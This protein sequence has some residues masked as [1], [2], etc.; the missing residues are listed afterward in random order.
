MFALRSHS[1]VCT[2]WNRR[3]PA[4]LRTVLKSCVAS[5]LSERFLFR[6]LGHKLY[7]QDYRIRDFIVW[8]LTKRYS[9]ALLACVYGFTG[10]LTFRSRWYGYLSVKLI[11]SCL[12]CC[13]QIL[14]VSL[15]LA[16]LS[17]S[18]KMQM[19][20][21][22]E[23]FCGSQPGRFRCPVHH[24]SHRATV[25]DACEIRPA[26]EKWAGSCPPI[27]QMSR[28]S[29][30]HP[31]DIC[32]GY[33]IVKALSTGPN[34]AQLAGIGPGITDLHWVWPPYSLGTSAAV[35]PR[36]WAAAASQ[37]RLSPCHIR[38][39]FTW[40]VIP[41]ALRNQISE[42]TNYSL[43]CTFARLEIDRCS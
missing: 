18:I 24:A 35:M 13:N 16:H 27:G 15:I 3:L 38:N 20:E 10:A 17:V 28:Y 1:G 33:R 21:K 32:R 43:D 19:H 11:K 14:S 22:R 26:A 23:S 5:S 8:Y 34:V 4:A 12:V 2:H 7:T 9:T 37:E 40:F 39:W 36:I 30:G 29:V 41:R 42:D 6:V 31:L 25:A